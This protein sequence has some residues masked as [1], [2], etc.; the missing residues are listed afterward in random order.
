VADGGNVKATVS[1][2]SLAAVM[3]AIGSDRLSGYEVLV[4]LAKSPVA[5]EP[6]EP[7]LYP[8]LH[9][10]EAVGRLRAGWSTDPS[11]RERR[12]YRRS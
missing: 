11:G 2:E 1:A 5:L 7:A 8:T 6:P 10:L 9:R 3:A 4:R 12:L